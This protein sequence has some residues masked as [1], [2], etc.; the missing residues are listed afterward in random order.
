MG[1]RHADLAI[2]TTDEIQALPSVEQAKRHSCNP[3]APNWDMCFELG[4]PPRCIFARFPKAGSTYALALFARAVGADQDAAGVREGGG[5]YAEHYRQGSVIIGQA[6]N[7]FTYYASVWCYMS[8]IWQRDPAARDWLQRSFVQDVQSYLSD[9][10]LGTPRGRTALARARFGDFVR[11]LSLPRLGHM[12]VRFWGNY[13]QLDAGRSTFIHNLLSPVRDTLVTDLHSD[14]DA[15]DV[16][17]ET[18]RAALFRDLGRV[19]RRTCWVRTES[20]VD[21]LQHCV[22]RCEHAL[23]TRHDAGVFHKALNTRRDAV[24]GWNNSS[25]AFAYRPLYPPSLEAFVRT[26]DA[27]IFA[28]FN[29]SFP[30]DEREERVGLLAEPW[31]SARAAEDEDAPRTD[32]GTRSRTRDR[33]PAPRTEDPDAWPSDVLQGDWAP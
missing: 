22:H 10:P 16:V 31:A 29:Y 4:R 9:E 25:Q 14:P 5:L 17:V 15:T 3:T 2:S 28:A 26:A 1:S 8:D 18:I 24:W 7:P 21:D 6:R 13:F 32:A 33:E 20:L 23:G 27:P 19:M 11:L 12:S 30:S